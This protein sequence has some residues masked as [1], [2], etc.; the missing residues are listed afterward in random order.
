MAPRHAAGLNGFSEADAEEVLHLRSKFQ[1]DTPDIEW[2]QRL[3]NDEDDDWIIISGDL[4]ITRNK[5]ER[6]AWHESG[7]TAF[8]F[9]DA[10]SRANYW[11]KAAD[12]V[13]WWPEIRRLAREHPSGHGYRIPAIGKEIKHIYP[14]E[15]R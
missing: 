14:D 6:Q 9:D 13:K 12:L 4:R 7:L 5:A 15:Q 8:F 10:W 2:M 1:P 11:R 3:A